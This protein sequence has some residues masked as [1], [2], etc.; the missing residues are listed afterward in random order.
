MFEFFKYKPD[1]KGTYLRAA[2]FIDGELGFTFIHWTDNVQEFMNAHLLHVGMDRMDNEIVNDG[3]SDA[4]YFGD[5]E[6]A[7]QTMMCRLKP[8]HR[9]IFRD[10]IDFRLSDLE[11]TFCGTLGR[12]FIL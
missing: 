2:H 11:F 10:E 1:G 4:K 3:R 7:W 12:E 9:D 8:Q 6:G 5:F